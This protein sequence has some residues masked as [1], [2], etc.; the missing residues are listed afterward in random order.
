VRRCSGLRVAWTLT[1]P[2]GEGYTVSVHPHGAECECG[3]FAFR[4]EWKD[5]AGCKHVRALRAF[6]L[7]P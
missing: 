6:R 1:K 4:R 7:V 5:P 2:D 3:D